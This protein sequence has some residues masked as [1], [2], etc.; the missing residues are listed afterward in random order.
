MLGTRW[1]SGPAGDTRV[2]AEFVLRGEVMLLIVAAGLPIA[3]YLLRNWRAS[4]HRLRQL[5]QQVQINTRL[6]QN[7]AAGVVACDKDGQ[8]SL[9][10]QVAI[11]WHGADA[12]R[13]QQSEW[14]RHYDLFEAD[15]KT[16]LLPER[17]PLLRAFNGESV[18][19]QMIVIAPKN[20]PRRLVSTNADA[21]TTNEGERV[22]AVAVMH[23]V[24]VEQATREAL[25]Q[26]AYVD[27]QTGLL[28]RAG[29]SR[30]LEKL[31]VASTGRETAWACLFLLDI[32][33]FR[34]INQALG[35]DIGD[36][37]LSAIAGRLQGLLPAGASLARI[38]ADEYGVLLG[39]VSSNQDAARS[40][41][42]AQSESICRVVEEPLVIGAN[43][44]R[45]KLNIGASLFMP[46]DA[47]GNDLLAQAGMALGFAKGGE[48]SPIVIYDKAMRD[49]LME[50]RALAA[51][52]EAALDNDELKVAFQPQCN[53]HGQLI[54]VEALSRW[55]PGGV[56]CSP[57]EFI[58]IAEDSGEIIRIGESVLRNSCEQLVRWAEDPATAG[59]T[60]SVNV[61]AQEL[62]ADDFATRTIEL[63]RKT[64]APMD[65]LHLEITESLL[66]KNAE[67]SARQIRQ[68]RDN[69]LRVVLDDFGTG[70]SSLDYLAK[71]RVDALKID[72]SFT[73]RAG[74]SGRGDILLQSIVSLA[75][76]LKLQ[77]VAEGVE[78][79]DQL[80]LLDRMGC[81]LFQGFMFDAAVP[82][83][84]LKLEYPVTTPA[85]QAPATPLPEAAPVPQG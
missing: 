36:Q 46:A 82:A 13:I 80:V 29:L 79:Q 16:P 51:A 47:N 32:F 22:G 61:S 3:I 56:P 71:L 5:D 6:M 67:H 17:I 49:V 35:Y 10:N 12:M 81:T 50:R 34:G 85:D 30:E 27:E 57:I 73:M 25:E 9:F 45:L 60:I 18:R 59:I 76:G 48:A 26:R 1:V 7:M 4:Q 11:D 84:E 37:V 42:L 65:R 55:A 41:L 64:G 53:R 8:L 77:I 83:D 38:G 66:L 14:G 54:G 75:K 68:L 19:G 58:S 2:S 72:R 23:D 24:T 39:Q 40:T 63:I 43:T 62:Q 31:A 70:Y 69:G 28:N 15:G 74:D 21:V 78:R 52:L 33:G 44:L 20:K